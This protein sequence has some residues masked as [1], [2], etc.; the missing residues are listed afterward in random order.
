[1]NEIRNIEAVKNYLQNRPKLVGVGEEPKLI[2]NGRPHPTGVN[3][4]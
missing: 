1:V 2:I 4:T 3:K